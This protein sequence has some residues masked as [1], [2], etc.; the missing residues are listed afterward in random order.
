[1]LSS[2]SRSQSEGSAPVPR[3]RS[4][5]A[6]PAGVLRS[7]SA[8]AAAFTSGEHRGRGPSRRELL[9]RRCLDLGREP[10]VR[11]ATCGAL[12]RVGNPGAG[13]DQHQTLDAPAERE[14][15]VQRDPTAE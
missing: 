13:A 8:C 15:R 6:S 1:M 2:P 9:D 11:G 14:R 7:R 3:P 4:A 12:R 10:L 5:A